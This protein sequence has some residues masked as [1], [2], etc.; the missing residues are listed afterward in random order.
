MK[1]ILKTEEIKIEKES[2]DW[3]KEFNDLKKN[4]IVKLALGVSVMIFKTIKGGKSEKHKKN[5]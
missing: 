5:N 1:E 4:K 2:V 3:L